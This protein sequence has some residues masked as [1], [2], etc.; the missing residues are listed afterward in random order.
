MIA[1][2]LGKVKGEIQQMDTKKYEVFAKTV[3]CASLTRAADELGLTQSGVSHIIASI[4]SE[5]KLP[6]LKRTRAGARL[7]PEGEK[8]MPFIREIIRQEKLLHAAAEGMRT[9][10]GG[11]IRIGTFTSVATHWLPAMMMCFQQKYPQVDFQLFNGD[12]HDVENWATD[13]SVDLAFI[14]LPTPLKCQC[15]PLYE[16][17]LM[18]VLPKGHPLAAQS[19][20]RVEDVAKESFISLLEASNHDAR[21]ALDAVGMKPNVRFRTKDDY[22]VIAMVRQGLG[23]S[24]MPSLLLRGNGDG[25]EIRPIDP[26]ASRTIA[27]AIPSPDPN[28]ATRRFADFAAEWVRENT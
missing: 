26:P 8:L 13:G 2:H 15:V 10:V 3:D 25:I 9:Q 24:I 1:L 17:P 21:R 4:E 7:T 16:D 22:A 5:F 19:I 28:A 11:T 6:L 12:Y 27:L 14:A 18:A 23:V 20:C